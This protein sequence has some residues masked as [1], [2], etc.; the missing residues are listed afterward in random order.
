MVG[1]GVRKAGFKGEEYGGLVVS[2]GV[3]VAM[4]E[5]E[6]SK[7]GSASKSGESSAFE[8]S[9]RVGV[10]QWGHCSVLVGV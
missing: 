5:L 9:E 6:Q 4:V 8:S 3:V 2:V 1:L 10:C 7:I